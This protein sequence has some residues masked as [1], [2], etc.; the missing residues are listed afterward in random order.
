M[1]III[2]QSRNGNFSLNSFL[3][4]PWASYQWISAAR[5]EL[6]LRR[7]RAIPLSFCQRPW[8][9]CLRKRARSRMDRPIANGEAQPPG[10]VPQLYNKARLLT[11][12][13][14]RVQP[15]RR[16]T[17]RRLIRRPRPLASQAYKRT[18]S[19]APLGPSAKRSVLTTKLT[20]RYGAPCY[21]LYFI[22][23]FHQFRQLS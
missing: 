9:Y 4:I 21:V 6:S 2:I 14:P 22:T 8:P 20:C 7:T 17:G 10:F 13:T 16:T 12:R 19:A 5:I 15:P 3:P 23:R 11:T 1:F 18:K